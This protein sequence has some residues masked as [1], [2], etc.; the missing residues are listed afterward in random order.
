[1]AREISFGN[2]VRQRRREMDLTQEEL[3]RRVGCAA[4]TLRK[5]EG[6][7]L[8]PSVQIAERLAMA[9]A[10]PLGERAE[11][12]RRARA[13][14]L[15]AAELPTITPPPSIDEIG[16]EDLS[17]RAIHGYA[18][19]ERIGKGGMG[20]VY[21]AVQ[22]N[23]E[24]EVAVKI[25]LPAYANHPDFIRRFEAE[26]QLVARLEHPH[27]VPLYDYWRE[28]GVAYLIMRLLRGGNVQTLLT[29]G[30]VPIETAS[31]VFEQMCSALNAAHRIGVIHR[32]LKPANVLLDEDNN[33]YLADFGIAK[34]ISNPDLENLTQID[35]FV[36]TPQYMSPEQ[37]RSLSVSP[38]SDIYCLG[39]LLYELLTGAQP[40]SGPT[41]IDLIQQHVNAPM[42]PLAAHHS[43]LPEQLDRVI[44]RATA[45]EPEARYTDAL[46]FYKEFRQA[47]GGVL[48]VP[49]ILIHRPEDDTDFKPANPFKG[50]RAFSE[51][52]AE[53][54]FGRE[55]L[56]QQLLSRL[57]EGGDLK[58][59]LAVIGPSGSGKSSVVRA[60]LIPA[61]RR[62]GLPGSEN[63][64][65]VDMLPG[66]HP[67]EELEASL[68]RIAVNPPEHLLSQ[69][70]DGPRGL[71]RT[72]RRILS[73]DESIELVLVIDQ[74]EE[75]FTLVEDEAERALLL[76]SLATA[77]L[78][79]RSRLRVI[80][81]L[82]A[83]F[84]DRPLRYV[85]FGELVNRRFEF[86]L[87]LTPDELERAVVNPAQRVGLKLEQG[88]V[89]TI[90]HDVGNQPGALPLLQYALSE[91]FDRR[92]G[93]LLTAKAYQEIG[94]VLGALGRSAEN[95][96]ASL[97]ETEQAAA[98]QLFLRLVTLGEGTED[99]RRRVLR[100]E[101]ET[102][103]GGSQSVMQKVIDVFGKARLL[104]FNRDPFTRNPTIEVAHEAILREWA[105]LRTWLEESRT[106]I[107]MQRQ[108]SNAAFEWVAAGRDDS[109]LL[110]G[111]KLSQ[112]EGWTEN[113][114]V[115]LTQ[116]EFEFLAAGRAA[117]DRRE[118]EEELRQQRELESVRKLAETES[119]RAELQTQSAKRLR[120]SAV[121]LAVALI[122]AVI[123]AAVALGAGVRNSRLATQNEAIASTAQ[124]AEA[125]ALQE[126]D[127]AEIAMKLSVS[128]E[129]AAAA[130]N[131]LEIDPERSL[132][133]ALQGLS[134][135]YSI[136]AEDALRSGMTA[137]HILLTI[138]AEEG[139]QNWDFSP[140]GERIALY[141]GGRQSQVRDIRTGEILFSLDTSDAWGII[142]YTP[143][144]SQ[145]TSYG[146]SGQI[147]H[148]DSDTG[149]LLS[150][151]S[152][153]VDELAFVVFSHDTT[154][155]VT[156]N[157]TTITVW[158]T[159]TGHNLF[160]I[161]GSAETLSSAEFSRDGSRLA[162]VAIDG[163]VQVWDG[164][165]G[166]KQFSFSTG[167]ADCGYTLTFGK[168]SNQL[169]VSGACSD[170][171]F[172][173]IASE[174]PKET[175][176]KE[177]SLGGGG[178]VYVSLT[179]DGSH[180]VFSGAIQRVEVWDMSTLEKVDS[181]SSG[182]QPVFYGTLSPD[183]RLFAA[184]TTE[185]TFKVWQLAL[186]GE[187]QVLAASDGLRVARS[188]YSPDGKQLAM[189]STSSASYVGEIQIY[190]IASGEPVRVIH[191]DMICCSLAFS[192]DG[193]YLVSAAKGGVRIWE[194]ASDAPV[195]EIN[196]HEGWVTKFAFNHEGTLL[197]TVGS[198]GTIKILNFPSRTLLRTIALEKGT[199]AYDLKFS[200]D[201]KTL[202]TANFLARQNDGRID[203]W[204]VSSGN[205]LFSLGE[206]LGMVVSTLDFS[207]DGRQLAGG[208]SDNNARVWDISDMQPQPQPAFVLRGHSANI[209]SLAY[210]PDGTRLAT[211]SLDHL[212]KLW[213][214]TPGEN[215]GQL[216]TTFPGHTAEVSDVSFSP[217]GKFLAVS[218]WDGTVR[219]Y[220]THIEDLIAAAWQRV[221]RSLTPEECQQYLHVEACPPAP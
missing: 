215:Q 189:L 27:I 202:A 43:G 192:P 37:V 208:Y 1:M 218:S 145:L 124:A 19:A 118:A 141:L 135:H 201:G 114:A 216:L 22:P 171:V 162:T 207:P 109:F 217:D 148:W 71:L 147:E 136:E 188:T 137:S 120:K 138:P 62:G 95:I 111:A 87:P 206:G 98:R 90:V 56:V 177:V 89:S 128:R 34:N 116:Q 36:G 54:F 144:G 123:A 119:S 11:F 157:M 105:R 67:F 7:D 10:I 210:S 70:K 166:E 200:P 26:A 106:L 6:D 176:R 94:G 152:V 149:E 102:L 174:E 193:K 204:E 61:L 13:M 107:R 75:V 181:F 184:A 81:T 158:D 197:A 72:V 155:M 82:R 131:N 211:A 173:D 191:E 68:L 96:H 101:I 60:G 182:E 63:W 198:E 142:H 65:I 58:R 24:R 83:D 44:M 84:T 199:F 21:R 186:P 183:N 14:P 220:L 150:S 143:D 79:E 55:T 168:D 139:V 69:L 52:D 140:D 160:Q 178:S 125:L 28:P 212:A 133:L 209:W 190:D 40:F 47:I 64:F 16:S 108:L 146:D 51:A 163:T 80:I 9:L 113:S 30:A 97:N 12:V 42:P 214:M 99:T 103:Q 59:F 195:E 2:F 49:P 29:Q 175:M 194:T 130:V 17:G 23:V 91:L 122:L 41:P 66:R 159:A 33:A 156:A 57:G 74:F 167:S 8:R 38:Q 205:L 86:I 219:V 126:R 48:D 161:P 117:R 121:F 203:L 164:L 85:D 213:D 129:L 46:A 3:A 77:V 110:T 196:G 169:I 134:T 73:A 4:I 187:K 78:D 88:L 32:D 15:E 92:E 18:L 170:V 53:N 154:R 100:E 112:Y 76:E 93:R 45:K 185:G 165:T 50:L 25:I 180:V 20:S 35:Q 221:T 179:H 5:I 151:L 104:S 115:A 127:Q 132:L 172:W 39:I 153:P 31:R